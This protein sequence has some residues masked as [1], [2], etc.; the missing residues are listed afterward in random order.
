MTFLWR[1]RITL[2]S[3]VL[4]AATGTAYVARRTLL[5]NIARVALNPGLVDT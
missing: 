1:R 5:L 2:L 3:A 4:I